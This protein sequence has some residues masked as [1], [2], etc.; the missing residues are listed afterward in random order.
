MLPQKICAF[1]T[2]TLLRIKVSA[3]KTKFYLKVGPHEGR[4]KV[5]FNES[6]AK[7]PTRTLGILEFPKSLC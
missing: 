5:T 3:R 6:Y 4:V 2:L 1:A 7:T